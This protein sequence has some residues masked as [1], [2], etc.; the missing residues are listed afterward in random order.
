M[1]KKIPSFLYNKYLLALVALLVWLTFFDRNNFISQVRYGRTLN[2]QRQQKEFYKSEIAK[3]STALVE[4]SDSTRL[5]KFAREKYLFKK[6]NEDIYLIVEDENN[7][8]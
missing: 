5:E 3:D 1:F 7:P 8:K 6:D 2:K 4:L